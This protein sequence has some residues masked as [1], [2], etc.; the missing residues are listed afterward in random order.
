[1]KFLG[2]AQ[3]CECAINFGNSALSF[4]LNAQGPIGIAWY[5]YPFLGGW[6]SL[7]MAKNG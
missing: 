1:M 2:S 7:K 6:K 3:K 4:R 5:S